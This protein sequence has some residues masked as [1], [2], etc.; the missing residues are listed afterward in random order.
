MTLLIAILLALFVLPYPWNLIVVIA[1]AVVDVIETGAFLWW[2][3]RRRAAVG[4][5]T[6]IGKKGVAV[7]SLWPDGQV[8]V[9]GE[10]WNARCEGGAD[11]GTPVVVRGIE[12]LTLE[13][14]PDA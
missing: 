1:A 8:R 3:R 11:A 7:G 9:D 13:V 5:E 4:A 14:E 2:S 6:L 12:G 10:L